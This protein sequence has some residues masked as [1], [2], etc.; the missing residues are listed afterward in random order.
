MHFRE[1]LSDYDL[2]YTGNQKR[3]VDDELCSVDVLTQCRE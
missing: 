3:A 1:A 2:D